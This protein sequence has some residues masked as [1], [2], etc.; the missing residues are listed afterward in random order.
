MRWKKEA[1]TALP[2]ALS[3]AKDRKVQDQEK[4]IGQLYKQISQ[5]KVKNGL[6]KKIL[7]KSK[8]DRC[9]FIDGSCVFTSKLQEW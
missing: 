7:A 9:Q 5:L 4:L 1:L 8:S 2:D 3:T 6:S